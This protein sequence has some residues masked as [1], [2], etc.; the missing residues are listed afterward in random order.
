MS[1]YIMQIK[2]LLMALKKLLR[3]LPIAILLLTIGV[4][5]LLSQDTVKIISYNLLNYS[6]GDSKN[7]NFRKTIKYADPDIL[8]VCEIISQSAV[9]DML[10]NVMN[11]YTPGSYAAGTFINGPDTDNAIFYKPSKFSFLG[12]YPIATALR[13]INM[14][15]LVHLESG[16]TIR[17][18][19]CH[20]KA[21]DGS[22]NEQLR[23][24]EVNILRSY[25]NSFAPGTE[26]IIG[27]DFN[28]YTA[29]EPGYQRLLQVDAGSQ[30]QFIDPY[31]LPG[32][33]NQSGYAQYH[34]QSTRIRQFEGGA[35]GGLDDRFDFFLN[36]KGITEEGRIKFIPNSLKAIGND[37][38]HYNDSINKRPNTSV[39]DSIADALYYGSD[40]LPVVA[41]YKF[42]KHPSSISSANTSEPENYRLYQNYPNPFNPS[43][44]IEYDLLSRSYVILK[45]YNEEGKEMR[46]LVDNIQ[47]PGSHRI[48][49]DGSD[50]PSGAYFYRL[51]AGKSVQTRSMMLVK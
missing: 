38:N 25:T 34:S 51:I 23:L 8:T 44:L 49:F 39:P 41:L 48:K 46:T 2:F 13:D 28:I 47:N 50:L 42:D 6:G 37:G 35:T 36:S 15:T 43:T 20:L 5:N 1:D 12:N 27:G 26:F 40:H 32:T 3:H 45:I 30:G 10:S 24:A 11:Y 14:F 33:W 19:E 22:S 18:F 29:N 17:I 31:N 16:D 7:Q 4:S 21:S 9:N